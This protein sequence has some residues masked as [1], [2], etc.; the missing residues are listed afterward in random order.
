MSKIP[1]LSFDDYEI[2]SLSFDPRESFD[3]QKAIVCQVE[4]GFRADR[5]S[6]ND[7]EFRVVLAIRLHTDGVEGPNLPYTLSMRLFGV[8]TSAVSLETQA[9]PTDMLINALTLLYGVCRGF[10]A[11]L[12]GSALYG[13]LVL[14]SV[15]FAELVAN[16]QRVEA[17]EGQTE[18][19]KA[20]QRAG[21]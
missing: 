19:T 13:K 16:A 20:D 15:A 2:H 21:A 1:Q 6:T 12:T 4:V 18:S 3:P 14:P 7:R 8:F 10:V 5:H 9:I 17:P 11:E